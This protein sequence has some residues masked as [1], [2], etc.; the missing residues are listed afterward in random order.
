MTIREGFAPANELMLHFA[1]SGSEDAPLA[2]FLHG[3]PE[4]WYC[5]K[6]VLEELSGHFHCVAPD[7]PGYN[8]SSRP[9]EVARYRTKRLVDDLDAFAANF[10]ADKPFILVAHDWGGALAWAYAI[11]KPEHLK[12]LVIINATHPGT[13][14]REIANNPAQ[15]GASQYILDI[16]AEGSEARFAANGYAQLWQSLAPV[17]AAGHLSAADKSEYLKAWAQPGALTG[18]F[19]WY[20]AMRLDPPK[21]GEGSNADRLYEPE[22]LRVSVPTLVIWGEQDKALL[23][24]CLDGLEEFVPNLKMIRVPH[25]S[26]WVIHEEPASV[27]RW[28]KDFAG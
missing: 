27:S 12:K 13:F 1:Q 7:L 4:F 17:A 21:S 2:L 9:A 22:T 28:I 3:F 14:A 23:P 5:W 10:S 18:M 8:L 15:A 6:D 11:K 16:R 19:N 24:G 26:H 25:G 20:R